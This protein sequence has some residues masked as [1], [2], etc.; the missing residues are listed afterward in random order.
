MLMLAAWWLLAI[1]D[2]GAQTPFRLMVYN[3]ENLFDTRHDS[4]KNDREF[5]PEAVRRWTPYRYWQK[6]D[7]VA[8][9]VAAVGQERLPDLV[10]L[11]EVENDTVLRD[12][13][14]RSSLRTVGYRYVMTDSPDRRGIDVALLYQPGM[15]RILHHRAFRVPSVRHGFPPTRDILYVCGKVLSGDT[16]HVFV[17][18]LPSRA[19]GTRQAE[20]HR[21]LALRTL[22]NAV[23]SLYQR[24]PDARIIVAGDFNTAA[25]EGAFKRSLRVARLP[26]GAG[27]VASR[28]APTDNRLYVT[29]PDSRRKRHRPLGSYRYRGEWNF[30]DHVLVSGSLLDSLATFACCRPV[31]LRTAD[32]PFLLEPDR[33]HGGVRPFRTYQGTVYRGGYSD[34]LPVYL[35]FVWRRRP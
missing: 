32:F 14:L 20:R 13:T 22:Q 3:V 10:A 9:V 18:H 15:F 27:S 26:A 2:A 16:L 12:L 4:L 1:P 25:G 8:K 5:L 35:D 30:L 7:K 19:G 28:P 6:L 34:H 17:C 29:A 31:E 21:R 33:T 24:C 23:D 11:C